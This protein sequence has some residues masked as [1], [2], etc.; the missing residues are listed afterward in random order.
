MIPWLQSR[1]AYVQ[2]A[3]AAALFLVA[4]VALSWVLLTTKWELG[5]T[6]EDLKATGEKLDTANR[7]L[8][9]CQASRDGLQAAISDQNAS[10]RRMQEE[11]AQAEK[12]GAAR[13]A[14]ANKEAARH[15]SRADALA[16]AKPGPDQCASARSLIVETLQSERG[17]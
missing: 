7:N 13:L 4:T 3:G 10:I 1:L 2:L 6:R 11:A 9:V 5:R 16:K 15:R 12:I 17:Q 8:G 14:A